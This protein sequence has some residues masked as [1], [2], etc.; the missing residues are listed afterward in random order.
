MP[1]VDEVT[2]PTLLGKQTFD[3]DIFVISAV[4]KIQRESSWTADATSPVQLQ[5]RGGEITDE[6]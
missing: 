2:T 4:A 1:H 3:A 5:L 6:G